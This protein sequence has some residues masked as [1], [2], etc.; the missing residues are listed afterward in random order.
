[1]WPQLEVL[2]QPLRICS[3][4]SFPAILLLQ[5]APER[6]WV[7]Y[8]SYTPKRLQV[9]A[10]PQSLWPRPF[11]F[12]VNPLEVRIICSLFNFICVL[13]EVLGLWVCVCVC[14][15]LSHLTITLFSSQRNACPL[16][17]VVKFSVCQEFLNV[18]LTTKPVVHA[19]CSK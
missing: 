17:P 12:S 14:F 6:W 11:F 10:Q 13:Y 5:F 7:S 19:Y 4:R 3:W 15:V 2:H 9:C 8:V 18:F 16:F 1:M